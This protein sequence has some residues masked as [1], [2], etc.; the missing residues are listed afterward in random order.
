MT[1]KTNNIVT[2]VDDKC[3][4]CVMRMYTIVQLTNKLGNKI[5]YMGLKV[6]IYK[7]V[8]IARYT[9]KDINTISK[10]DITS[11]IHICI[12]RTNRYKRISAHLSSTLYCLVFPYDLDSDIEPICTRRGIESIVSNIITI[13]KLI[14]VITYGSKYLYNI[15]LVMITNT[16]VINNLISNHIYPSF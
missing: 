9:N 5:I 7:I 8:P 3:H 16:N 6:W 13:I 2:N 15:K 14:S 4:T 10:P 12:Y 1:L 11:T